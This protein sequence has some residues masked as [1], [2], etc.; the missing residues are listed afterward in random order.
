[1]LCADFSWQLEHRWAAQRSKFENQVLADQSV[2]FK[3]M[4]RQ[5]GADDTFPFMSAGQLASIRQVTL[6]RATIS[7]TLQ[8]MRDHGAH[9]C[10]ALVLWLGQISP[11]AGVASVTFTYVPPQEAIS[12]EDGV[13]YFVGG[14]TLFQLNK[15]LSDT[16]LRLIAQVHSHPKEAYH[17][18][19][20]D[21]YA[22]VTANGGL[23]LVVPNFGNAPPTPTAW[24][25]YRLDGKKWRE[26][27]QV[28][29]ERLF[30]VEG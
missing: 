2:P 28:D 16:G 10:E 9:G 7:S 21:R 12:S 29:V 26:L 1:M 30:K 15:A 11:V 20:D 27:S 13:G 6:T 18:A 3:E 24:A 8:T 25:V 14:N 19:A 5:H 22:I 23:S 17:S 4:V